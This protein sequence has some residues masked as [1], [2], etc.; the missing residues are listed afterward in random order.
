[1]LANHRNFNKSKNTRLNE[2]DI[3]KLNLW[4]AGYR[5]DRSTLD[6]FRKKAESI[7]VPQ[8]SKFRFSANRVM[9]GICMDCDKP[10]CE[11]CN[12]CLINSD[13]LETAHCMRCICSPYEEQG[14][15][16]DIGIPLDELVRKRQ[17]HVKKRRRLNQ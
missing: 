1:L 12:G 8:H 15:L 16:N 13:D 5:G 6:Y 10:R 17:G 9:G 14:P 11:V 3:A 2:Y 7:Y 4:I